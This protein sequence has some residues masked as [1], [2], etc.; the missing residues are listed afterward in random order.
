MNSS[1]SP[2]WNHKIA[3]IISAIGTDDFPQALSDSLLSIVSDLSILLFVCPKE[4]QPY[5]LFDNYPKRLHEINTT[6]WLAG[7]YLL[8][9][10][11]KKCFD[12]DGPGLYHLLELVPEGFLVSKYYHFYY[13]RTQC[14]D[15]A[16]YLTHIGDDLRVSLSIARVENNTPFTSAEIATLK[17]VEPIVLNAVQKHFKLVQTQANQE[18]S[19]LHSQL[20]SGLVAFGTSL[21]TARERDII[22]LIL[23]GHSSKS[24]C[25]DL[26]ISLDT[27]KMHRR[28]AYLKLKIS[29]QAELFSLVFSAL[30]FIEVDPGKDPLALYLA[31][32]SE[33]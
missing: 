30:P 11:Y 9:P 10:F 8:D 21:L 28:N 23:H 2:N 33:P 27:V 3:D 20:K 22:Q 7:A 6:G 12:G 32:V 4:Q 29:K 18:R 31:S 26:N 13:S 5:I 19:Q 25:K 17:A 16:C 1:N 24:I 15:E 14:R